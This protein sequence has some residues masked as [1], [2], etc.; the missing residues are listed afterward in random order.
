MQGKHQELAP[1][2]IRKWVLKASSNEDGK[3]LRNMQ[4]KHQELAP[5]NIRKWVLKTS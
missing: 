2:N 5:E 1:E 4:G 3:K